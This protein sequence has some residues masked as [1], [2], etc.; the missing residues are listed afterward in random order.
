MIRA[1]LSLSRRQ[2]S[3]IFVLLDMALVPAA[4]WAAWTL[5]ALH[6]GPV[7]GTR[8]M[9][10]LSGLMVAAGGLSAVLGLATLRLKDFDGAALLRA[11]LLSC[12]LSAVFT[13][14]LVVARVPLQ[15]GVP[16]SFGLVYFVSFVLLRH[17]LL[18][19]VTQVYRRSPVVTRVA[20]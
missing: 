9:I 13:A 5:H 11:G 7:D 17:G 4:V 8:L 15:V 18:W 12:A 10:G 1:V 14:L 6:P 16:V 2:K 20:I 19:A 3:G